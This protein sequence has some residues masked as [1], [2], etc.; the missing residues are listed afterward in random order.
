VKHMKSALP[1]YALV[2]PSN[3]RLGWKGLPWANTLAYYEILKITAVKS[4][5]TLAPGHRT[6][7]RP[8]EKDDHLTPGMGYSKKKKLM[9]LLRIS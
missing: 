6:P 3:I 4:F 8:T 5:I 2:V 7:R 9:K 1:V